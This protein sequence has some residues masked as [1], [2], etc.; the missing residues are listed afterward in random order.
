MTLPRQM[1]L[2][3]LHSKGGHLS[4][5]EIHLALREK[6]PS[7]GLTTVYRTL[8]LLMEFG[9]VHKFDFGDGRARYEFAE[10]PASLGHHHHL[11]CTS[12][13]RIIDYTDFIKEET[14]LM[15]RTEEGLSKKYNFSIKSHQL[16]FY[17]LCANCAG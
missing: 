17:G 12:C 2:D 14:E 3:F 13:K 9:L 5:E 7:M 1:I 6:L 15:R 16:Q 10:G 8:E 11:V 4:V